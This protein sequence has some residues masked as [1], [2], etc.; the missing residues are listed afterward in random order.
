MALKKLS[1]TSALES[2]EKETQKKNAKKILNNAKNTIAQNVAPKSL[3]ITP[4]KAGPLPVTNLT[5]NAF[6]LVP[7]KTSKSTDISSAK[8]LANT[9]IRQTLFSP[10]VLPKVD[11]TYKEVTKLLD[12]KSYNKKLGTDNLLSGFL[13]STNP[14]L[15]MTTS[16]KKTFTRLYELGQKERAEEYLNYIQKDLNERNLGENSETAKQYKEWANKHKI[17]GTVL[18]VATGIGDI[19]QGLKEPLKK[20]ASNAEIDKNA[21]DF[22]LSRIQDWT[23][24]GVTKDMGGVGKF[25]Y[26][27][28]ASMGQTAIRMPLGA[29]GLGMAGLS[30]ASRTASDTAGRGATARQSFISGVA[31]GGLEAI[32]EKIPLDSLTALKN[33]P[34]GATQ[35]FAKAVLKQSGTEATEETVTELANAI[36]DKIIMGGKSNY[37]LTK[38][39]YIENGAS[40]NEARSK[41]FM[42]TYIKQPVISG[43]GGALSGGIFGTAGYSMN[44]LGQKPNTTV[45]AE[46]ETRKGLNTN[47]HAE[48]E[49]VVST[50]ESATPKVIESSTEITPVAEP[51]KDL[52]PQKFVE[53]PDYN[54]TIDN[55]TEEI[56]VLS[57]PNTHEKMDLETY[58]SMKNT[59]KELKEK[60]E[61]IPEIKRLSKIVEEVDGYLSYYNMN[62]VDSVKSSA[63]N[64]A[65]ELAHIYSFSSSK[66]SNSNKVIMQAIKNLTPNI[67]S[68]GYLSTEDIKQ[69]ENVAFEQGFVKNIDEIKRNEGVK[70]WLKGLRLYVSP[71]TKGSITDYNDFRK[72]FMGKIGSL[73]TTDQN[74]TSIDT[75]YQE[76]HGMW[77]EHFPGDIF[78]EVDQL[79]RIR[80]VA[81][82][83]VLKKTPISEAWK[84]SPDGSFDKIKN[85]AR[86]DLMTALENYRKSVI[87]E[88]EKAWSDAFNHYNADRVRTN[89]ADTTIPDAEVDS[90]FANPQS[91]YGIN[92]V[93]S[94][95]YNPNSLQALGEKYG[96]IEEGENPRS[97]ER[98]VNIPKSLD[99]KTKVSK[100][101]RTA[102]ENPNLDNDMEMTLEQE[103]LSGKFNYVPE[104]NQQLM[105]E[106][107]K[108]IKELGF[109]GALGYWKGLMAEDR[110]V[111]D[112]DIALISRLINES[113]DAKDAK[114]TMD[115]ITDWAVIGNRLGKAMQAQKLLKRASPEG[116][117][118]YLRK[119]VDEYNKT[120][121]KKKR[122]RKRKSQSSDTPDNTTPVN[123][124]N[125]SDSSPKPVNPPSD[126]DN[127][128]KPVNPPNDSDSSPTPVNPPNDS[129][130]NHKPVNPPNDGDADG[131]IKIPEN[132]VDDF[133]N[134][135]SEDE[136]ERIIDQIYME[137]GRQLPFSWVEQWNNW[138]YFAMLANPKTHIRNLFGNVIF[139]PVRRLKNMVGYG[140][141]SGVDSL[142]RSRGKEGLTRTKFL[143]HSDPTYKSNYEFAKMLYDEAPEVYLG[144][145]KFGI[146]ER[147][148]Q[149]KDP[150]PFSDAETGIKKVINNANRV[151][152][153]ASDFNSKLL[154]KEDKI[155]FKQAFAE[156]LAEFMTINNLPHDFVNVPRGWEDNQMYHR[157]INYATQEARKATYRDE[158]ALANAITAF[159]KKGKWAKFAVDAIIPFKK[160]PINV[161]RR[162]LEYSPGGVIKGLSDVFTK[163]RYGQMYASDALDEI[164]SG[165]TGTGIMALGAF[166]ASKGFIN[167]VGDDEKKVRSLDTAEG[168]QNYALNIGD[169]SETIDWSA[170]VALPLFMGV[171]LWESVKKDNANLDF[172]SFVDAFSKI[173]EPMFELSVLSGFND[174]F[175]NNYANT[176][177]P[178]LQIGATLA[179]NY[180]GQAVPTLFGQV[181]RTL[182]PVRRIYYVDNNY[183]I[184]GELQLFAQRQQAKIPGL[185]T[186][187]PPMQDVWGNE[188]RN[189]NIA[190]RFFENFINPGYMTKRESNEVNTELKGLYNTLGETDVLP[191][192]PQKYSTINDAKKNYSPEDYEKATRLK[193][194]TA[195]NS[196]QDIINSSMYNSLS[197]EQK[198][199]AITDVYEY[200]NAITRDEM[201]SRYNPDKWI[202]E[203]SQGVKETGMSAGEIIMYRDMINSIREGDKARG[204]SKTELQDELIHSLNI[205]AKQKNWL[206]KNF[207][208]RGTFIPDNDTVVDHSSEENFIISQMPQSAQKLYDNFAW[209]YIDAKEYEKI[210]DVLKEGTKNEKISK[211]KALGY[212]PDFA[213]KI[214]YYKNNIKK[215][216][217]N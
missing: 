72:S 166:L 185:N 91:S 47:T 38:N 141:E 127:S 133:L 30:Q 22:T 165:L 122:K 193:G 186:K 90:T 15:N 155:F 70:S 62:I 20:F 137:I 81:E 3:E 119:V 145:A 121:P 105:A 132:L 99:G 173:S 89:D 206:S 167:G 128:P 178:G 67:L 192:K 18:N 34:P 190:S 197:A 107:E 210:Y 23:N 143:N 79:I 201:D 96:F 26:G 92:T 154:D 169:Y 171:E 83:L 168:F 113:I 31:S 217:E 183:R 68:K 129:A 126:S 51:Q 6:D 123:P 118:Y 53:K 111:S 213:E 35:S 108:R 135:G 200:A 55:S 27:V 80:E 172:M 157:A 182:D 10:E 49:N 69:L 2:L 73:T 74:A 205:S 43:L 115:L 198:R 125:D 214:V 156:S 36:T 164:A 177:N 37:D 44:K 29:L 87:S 170:P 144:E 21:E 131:G 32:L 187:L 8:D 212:P 176:Q 39:A 46:L 54:D 109:D 33:A 7:M 194:Q 48:T 78:N 161:L 64:L 134:A 207:V 159:A 148:E 98:V 42:G 9:R 66:N 149:Y 211:L 94:A 104:T 199:G 191:S 95:E 84:N 11:T 19:G 40:E 120:L 146:R 116:K 138:R 140:L 101:A 160:T 181:A 209:Q 139:T 114:L 93:G 4:N 52:A 1:T 14:N 151:F 162:G 147:I 216:G 82:S 179:S 97:T 124:P 130:S 174:L 136:R 58:K 61:N 65:E 204:K 117:L 50:Q 158:S 203:V 106:A 28:G 63:D 180:F 163:V 142:L 188:V 60:G 175:S 153:K 85:S 102:A 41:A 5:K 195:Y 75:A 100:T 103:I 71:E 184:P 24:E 45:E 13:Y 150:V 77:P 112:K 208:S 12:N 16:E 57:E 86:A 202:D 110:T 56:S 189:D 25:L 59:I 152:N 17:A 196:I 215:L 88:R 76:L